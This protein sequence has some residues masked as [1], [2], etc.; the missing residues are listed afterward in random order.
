MLIV[1]NPISPHALHVF[2]HSSLRCRYSTMSILEFNLE[3]LN[4]KIKTIIT[5]FVLFNEDWTLE[6]D[7]HGIQFHVS[8]ILK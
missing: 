8:Y 7:P 2:T 6:S 4:Y 1:G 5:F 3:I